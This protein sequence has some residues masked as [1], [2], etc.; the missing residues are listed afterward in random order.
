MS[1][2]ILSKEHGVNPAIPKCFYCLE[3]KNE[4]ILTGRLRDDVEAPRNSV[5]DMNPCDQCQSWMEQ[6]IILISVRNGEMEKVN[7][8]LENARAG[9]EREFGYR[10]S[11]WKEKH[12]FVFVPNPFRSGGWVVI[13]DRVI[14]DNIQ[15][16]ELA[17]RILED[18][19]IFV[20]DEMWNHMGLTYDE[21]GVQEDG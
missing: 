8:D 1:K 18:R 6:G 4:L 11:S 3:D 21:Q 17:Q 2:I 14:E 9:W 19:W 20:P 16:D 5:W 7:A 12:P 15:P 10:S 13:K